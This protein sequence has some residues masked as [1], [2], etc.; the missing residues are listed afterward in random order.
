MDAIDELAGVARGLGARKLPVD[1][2]FHSVQMEGA[3]ARLRGVAAGEEE[4]FERLQFYSSVKGNL[5]NGP[6]DGNYLA[7]NVREPVRFAEAISAMARDGF[8][9]FVEI[10]PHPASRAMTSVPTLD[11]AGHSALVTSTMQRRADGVEA[12]KTAAATLYVNGALSSLKQMEAGALKAAQMPPYPMAKVRHWLEAAPHGPARP[13]GLLGEEKTLAFDAEKS[14]CEG[15]I[16]TREMSFLL[17]HRIM[18]RAVFPAAGYID[19]F[20]MA[21]E[22]RFNGSPFALEEVQFL[23]LLPLAEETEI[24]LQLVTETR[25][26]GLVEM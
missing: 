23:E 18:G 4:E 12:V 6:F 22:R 3:A 26:A 21:A 13:Q 2:A 17:D 15:V 16:D 7:A 11:A 10:T 5:H 1:Y 25:T 9:T 19:I 20:L 24:P 14:F 8:A